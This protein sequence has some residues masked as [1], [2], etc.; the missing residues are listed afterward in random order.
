MSEPG[1]ITEDGLAR[2]RAR[3][4]IP[5]PNP[6][7]PH[8]RCPGVDA[9]RHVAEAYG[10]DNPLWSDPEHAA[11][12]RWGGVIAPP[13]L[14]GVLDKPSGFA[15]R[16]VHEWTA[17]VFR[18]D[19]RLLAAQLRLMA[20][21]ERG[22]ARERRRDEQVAPTPYTDDELAHTTRTPAAAAASKTRWVASRFRRR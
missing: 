22:E 3:I 1:R 10:D 21:T 16:A 6:Q 20:R 7:P 17:Q 4:G 19:E 14:V 11:A 8:Y 5:E 18:D 12:T 2:L 13:A 15:G 9:F